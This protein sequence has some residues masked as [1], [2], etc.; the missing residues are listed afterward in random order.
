MS[1]ATQILIIVFIVVIPVW[2][3]QVASI[4]LTHLI[5]LAKSAEKSTLPKGCEKILPGVIGDGYMT[6]PNREPREISVEIVRVDDKNPA[7]GSMVQGQ[8]RLRNTSK[9]PIDIPWNADPNRVELG[10][11]PYH[12]SWEE[13]RFNFVLRATDP[14]KRMPQALYG[15]QSVVG[16]M[17]KIQPGEWVTANVAFTLELEY[18]FPGQPIKKGDGQLQ[19]EWE[20]SWHSRNI[21]DCSLGSGYFTYRDYYRQQNP[22]ITIQIEAR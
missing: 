18:P 16:S 21:K 19:V 22:A 7:A 13:G 6:P 8:V 20:Q 4:D 5:T 1:R 11:D 15:S 17:L 3:Q 2:A 12:S 14:L 10:Q 9:Y